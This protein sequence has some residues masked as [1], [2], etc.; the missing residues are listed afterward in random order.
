[1]VV[2]LIEYNSKYHQYSLKAI[3]LTVMSLILLLNKKKDKHICLW[4]KLKYSQVPN[5]I[6]M[7][8]IKT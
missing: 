3:Y 8:G 6:L 5:L 2:C 7:T 1:M 4:T